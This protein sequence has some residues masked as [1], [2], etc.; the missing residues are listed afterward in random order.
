MTAMS[1]LR[2]WASLR[3]LAAS[4]AAARDWLPGRLFTGRRNVSAPECWLSLA[5]GGGMLVA[6]LRRRSLTGMV[7]GGGL[8]ARG[9]TGHC[10]LYQALGIGASAQRRHAGWVAVAAGHGVRLDQ[11]VLIR[12]AV[13]DVFDFWRNFENLPRVLDHLYSVEMV[14]TSHTHWIAKGPLGVTAQWDA[15]IIN[16]RRGQLI[17]WRSLPGGDLNTAGAV[18]FSPSPDGFGTL[19]RVELKYDPPGGRLGLTLARLLGEDPRRQLRQD[20]ARVKDLLEGEEEIIGDE[21][22]AGSRKAK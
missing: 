20:L 3:A 16:E 18:R 5:A 2:A 14:G 13:S 4:G 6:G 17:A 7:L 12:R 10:P 19:L 11:R 22:P 9:V 15:E 21:A 8:L 1:S